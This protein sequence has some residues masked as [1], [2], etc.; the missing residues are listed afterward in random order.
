MRALFG[1]GAFTAANAHAAAMTL[2]AYAAGLL[3]FVLMR[4]ATV[5][6]LSRGDTLTPVK[7][8]FVAVAVNVGLKILLM[9]DYAQVGLALATSV[10]AWINL[11]LLIWF[12]AR[13][14]LVSIDANLRQSC[15]K[16]AVA[17]GALAVALYFFER[18]VA[19]LFANWTSLRD[20]AILLVLATI[21]VVVYGGLVG[22]MF[23]R[24]WQASLRARPR[25]APP[26]NDGTG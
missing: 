13:Q 12:A 4:T 24:R 19:Q 8:L 9:D 5:T 18:P 22:A 21:G 25:A 23:R 10:G 7:A 14:R 6:F 11:A 1:R 2:M 3:P 20:V 17:G 16:L 26:R 15:I